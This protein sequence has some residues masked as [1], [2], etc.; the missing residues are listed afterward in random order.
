MLLR[1]TCNK[2]LCNS[3]RANQLEDKITL[4]KGRIED[5]SLPVEKVDIIIS[6]WMVSTRT[7]RHTHA[8]ARTHTHIGS[9]NERF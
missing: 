9:F 7:H 6:E 8:Q 3:L 1:G 5:I 4:I 2:V